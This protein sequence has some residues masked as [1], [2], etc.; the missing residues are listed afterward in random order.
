MRRRIIAGNWKMHKT[1][2]EAL[3]F[4][5]EF[6]RLEPWG[7]S[8]AVICP[9]F[10]CLA[11]L[12]QVLE[13]S[14]VALGAQDLHWEAQ[15]AFTGEVSGRM[16]RDVGCRYVIVGHSE[17]R[18]HFGD[19]DER[20]ALKTRAALDHGL[21]PIVCVGE[22]LDERESGQAEGIVVSQ[23]KAAIQDLSPQ[24]LATVVMA[25]EPVWA[26]GTGRSARGGD[27]AAMAEAVRRV[28]SEVAGELAAE[29]LRFLYGGSV[30]AKNALEFLESPGVD[31]ALVGGASLDP[32]EFRAILAAA[33]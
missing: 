27:A 18:Q 22:S 13:G 24:T 14:G 8:Q 17:R 31:G 28:V 7:E 19:N 25:Y 20:V 32:V 29:S 16:L 4:V 5:D 21:T 12:A 6:L 33:R 30:N 10:P 23:V 26:I 3:A 15:G 1:I 9:P 11:P 2:S